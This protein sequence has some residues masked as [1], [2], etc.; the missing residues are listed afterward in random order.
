MDFPMWPIVGGVCIGL[1]A[2]LLMALLGRIA[3]I[4]GIF[5]G[6]LAAG[7]SK[8]DRAWRWIF[9]SGLVLGTVAFHQLF[10][11]AGQPAS[12]YGPARA[13]VAGLLVGFGVKLGGGCTSGHGV[14]GMSRFSMRS[15][16]ATLVFMGTGIITVAV[17]GTGVSA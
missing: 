3:G 4:S 16:L 1:A 7:T 5:W 13:I 12:P 15:T 14:C 6:A 11:E 10:A 9:L 2:V 17:L 8:D